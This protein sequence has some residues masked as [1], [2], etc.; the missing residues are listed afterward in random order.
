MKNSIKKKYRY[1]VILCLL[2]NSCWAYEMVLEDPFAEAES[3]TLALCPI[4]IQQPE[5]L[6]SFP[7]LAEQ[8]IRIFP[9]ELRLQVETVADCTESL[10]RVQRGQP[11]EISYPFLMNAQ[12]NVH[13][14]IQPPDIFN[15]LQ[16]N[17]EPTLFATFN[18]ELEI[19]RKN[20]VRRLYQIHLSES[21]RSP[22]SQRPVLMEKLQEKLLQ[23]LILALQPRYRYR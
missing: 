15:G 12:L 2:L 11:F 7:N 19:W 1:L 21:A 6:P 20:P 17:R 13:E 18:L 16:Q 22:V 10:K 14:L 8:I 9:R 3:R 5:G 23:Q 4:W